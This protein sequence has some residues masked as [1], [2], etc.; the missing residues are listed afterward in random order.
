[1][2]EVGR[3]VDARGPQGGALQVQRLGA[4]GLRDA[5]V[6]DQHVSQT[7]VCDMAGG[8]LEN[9]PSGH[10]GRRSGSAGSPALARAEAPQITMR[11]ISSTVTVSAVR[12]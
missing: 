2:V 9:P 3:A 8:G 11:S 5:G 12:S 6:A 1:M 7:T 10:R 4:I